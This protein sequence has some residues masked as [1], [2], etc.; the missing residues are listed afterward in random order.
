ML[1]QETT[2]QR[3]EEF[4]RLQGAGEEVAVSDLE[5][6]MG[7]YSLLTTRFTV[8]TAAG[9]RTYVLR[10]DPP[11]DAALTHTDRKLESELLRVLTE[12]CK[13]PMPAMRWSDDGTVLGS[14]SIIV[15]FVDGPQ[16]LGHLGQASDAEQARLAL[17]LAEAIATVHNLGETVAPPAFPRPSSWD[18]YIDGFIADWRH[19][20]ASYV[21][22]EPFIRWVASWLDRHRPP[23]A[24]LTLVHGEFQTGNV[25]L[26]ASGDMQII[27]WEYA[28]VGDPRIDLGWLQQ[29]AAFTPPDLI[30]IDPMG[31]CDR[32]CEATGLSPEVI[33]PLTIA[34]FSIL[35]GAKALGGLLGG[36]AEMAHGRNHLMTS[37]YLVSAMP[38]THRLWRQATQAIE[39]A[40]QALEQDVEAV[41]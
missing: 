30:G 7:G 16:L 20:E 3:L 34:Y 39:G 6:L 23:P 26:S 25:M 36:I 13:A 18:A 15:D 21:E 12:S 33:N 4:L 37:A 14:P 31:F 28:H 35:S 29:V 2:R 8:T 17:Q 27:D 10:A 32:Y 22:R 5:P 41:R 40:M 19:L 38:Y 1:D 24:P 11:R 9:V